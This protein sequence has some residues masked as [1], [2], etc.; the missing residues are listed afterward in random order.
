MRILLLTHRMP[1]PPD[2]GD[3]IRSFNLLAY[4]SR[5]HE[6]YLASLLDDSRD[7]VHIPQVRQRVAGFV[8]E[9]IGRGLRKLLCLRG[10]LLGSSATVTYF[11][12]PALQR[13]I[14]ALIDSVPFDCYFCFSSPMAEYLYRSRHAANRI[15]GALR[16]MDLIDID[17]HKWRQYAAQAP[18]W[19][20]WVYGL[21]ARYL[22]AYER[23][24]A[25]TFDQLY[26]VSEQERQ[27]FP[28]ATRMD[29]LLALSNGVDL[30]FFTP[31]FV[32]AGQGQLR[33][34]SLVF[35][36]VM[37]YWPNI[38]GITW[39]VERLLPRIQHAVPDAQLYI[40]GSRPTAD[41]QKLTRSK[42][43]NVT[44]YVDDVRHYIAAASVCIVPLTI[45]RG[46]QNK[47][48]EAMAMGKAVVTTAQAFEGLRAIAGEDIIVADGEE[49][50]A[51]A[52]VSLMLDVG[53]ARDIGARARAR[54]VQNYAWEKN[55]ALLGRLGL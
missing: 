16:V 29:K 36:G 55:L 48:L 39:F 30:E 6:V 23:R 49:D 33:G 1:F 14:D 19:Q 11:Y 35:T 5:R 32:S 42:G 24:M 44:G 17:S 54:T 31:D 40:V 38:Q 41:V 20:A 13:R 34:L 43:V 3:K 21:E 37:D 27:L 45:A 2:R 25:Q 8:Y 12:S 28:D 52:V 53:R 10:L 9:L 46:I 22:A 50:F 47:V 15:A 7:L 18:F 4:L 51:A 26:V